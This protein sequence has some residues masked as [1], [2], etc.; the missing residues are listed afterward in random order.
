VLTQLGVV[1]G[2]IHIFY[3]VIMLVMRPIAR[4]SF[5]MRAFKRLY[6]A[7]TDK[8]DV[9]K[10]YTQKKWNKSKYVF[11]EDMPDPEFDVILEENVKNS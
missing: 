2:L 6:L 10:K 1:S 7:R 3:L 8:P 5:L 11:G 9:F 4:H